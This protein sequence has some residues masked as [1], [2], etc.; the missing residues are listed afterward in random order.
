MQNPSRIVDIRGTDLVCYANGPVEL[1]VIFL[2]VIRLPIV[3]SFGQY[4]HQAD[5][6]ASFGHSGS[7]P[8]K[9]D[10]HD[11]EPRYRQND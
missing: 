8:A 7:D 5:L 1:G 11:N 3:A 2:G 10:G 4:D 6:D 9:L